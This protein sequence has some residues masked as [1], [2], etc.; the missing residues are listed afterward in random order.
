MEEQ[1][2]ILHKLAESQA[3]QT[4]TLAAIQATLDAQTKT[5]ANQSQMLANQTDILAR[6][7]ERACV[8]YSLSS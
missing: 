5:L 2:T 6:L 4:D 8:G 7:A 1:T 3:K